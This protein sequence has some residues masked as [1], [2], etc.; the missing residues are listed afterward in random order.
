MKTKKEVVMWDE[1]FST[2]EAELA[3][4]ELDHK[5]QKKVVDKLAAQ[6]ILRSYL[7]YINMFPAGMNNDVN[8]IEETSIKKGIK[9]MENETI[10]VM[11]DDGQEL[12]YIIDE[13]FEF[14]GNTYVVLCTNDDDEEAILFRLETGENEEVLLY[15]LEDDEFDAVNEYYVSLFDEEGIE[16]EE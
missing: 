15:D 14:E 3:I 10:I 1:R 7:D 6:V 4:G 12:E 9:N 11:T 2:K 16:D 13:E 8:K 5:K